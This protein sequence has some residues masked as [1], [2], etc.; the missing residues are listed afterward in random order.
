MFD[1][2][3]ECHRGY[4]AEAADALERYLDRDAHSGGLL[5]CRLALGVALQHNLKYTLEV[6]E[7]IEHLIP[8]IGL[9]VPRFISAKTSRLD[10]QMRYTNHITQWSPAAI[11]GDFR[12]FAA[13]KRPLLNDIRRH[14]HSLHADM[15]VPALRILNI[16]QAGIFERYQMH[17][18]R[19]DRAAL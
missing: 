11:A 1:I 6:C 15:L 7:R 5:N 10:L 14:D 17:V 16:R 2:V 12:T 18:A 9:R 4:M 13:C 19:R 8:D 3:A